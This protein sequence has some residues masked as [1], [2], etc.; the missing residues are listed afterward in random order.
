MYLSETFE[1]IGMQYSSINLKLV[2]P[3]DHD[4]EIGVFV[5]HLGPQVK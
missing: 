4:N 2:D 3:G 1:K 5:I